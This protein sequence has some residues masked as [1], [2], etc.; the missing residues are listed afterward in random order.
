[1]SLSCTS[2]SWWQFLAKG[3]RWWNQEEIGSTQQ[4]QNDTKSCCADK[5]FI[6]ATKPLMLMTAEKLAPV[7]V[8]FSTWCWE[9]RIVYHAPLQTSHCPPHINLTMPLLPELKTWF[10]FAFPALTAYSKSYNTL[11]LLCIACTG[12]ISYLCY[13]TEGFSVTQCKALK[14]RHVTRLQRPSIGKVARKHLWR[15]H[16]GVHPFGPWS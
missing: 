8:A 16:T 11:L 4:I 12:H 10:W 7:S 9:D 1:M 13:N 3:G 6:N 2:N 15:E 5:T 14:E